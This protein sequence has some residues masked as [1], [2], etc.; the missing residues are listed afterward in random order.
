MST[1]LLAEKHAVPYDGGTKAWFDPKAQS[2][3]TPPS[4]PPA[5]RALPAPT[6]PAVSCSPIWKMD[7]P[8]K[9]IGH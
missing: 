7:G 3:R 1:W 9:V 4:G 8:R 5:P 2:Q 6:T